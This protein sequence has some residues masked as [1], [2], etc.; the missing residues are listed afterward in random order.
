MTQDSQRPRRRRRETNDTPQIEDTPPP[1]SSLINRFGYLTPLTDEQIE[2]IHEEALV[3]L[4]TAGIRVLSDQARAHLKK[5]G[6]RV[7]NETMMVFADADFITENIAKAPPNFTLTPR[8]PSH[9]ITVGGDIV[10]FGM[11]SGPPNVSDSVRGRRASQFN[12]FK[13][14]IKLGQSFQNIHFFGNQTVAT[15]DLDVHTRHLD[16]ILAT[17][18]LSDKVSACMS[19]G[20]ERVTDAAA[21][22]AIAKGISLDEMAQDPAAITNININS[23]RVLDKEMSDA[24]MAMAEM[25]Q[26][27]IVTPFTLMGAMAPV[28]IPAALTQQN[29]EALFTI[30]LLQSWRAGCKVVYGGFTSNVDMKS[31]A[32]AF[33]TPENALTNM[34]GGQLARRYN[35]PYRS[36]GCNASNTPDAQAVFETQMSLWGA[37][38]GGANLIYHS[39]GWLEGGLVASYE[40]AI[41]DADMLDAFATMMGKISFDDAEFGREAITETPPGGHFFGHGHTLERYKS[42]FFAPMLSDWQNFENWEAAGSL[43]A[44]ERAA[45]A[46]Q[47]RLKTFTPPPI[48]AAVAEALEAYVAR[49]IEEIGDRPL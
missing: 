32:P 25:G 19:V 23:P 3:I 17:L 12:D 24:A 18:T 49:R 30:A 43:T 37:V 2:R 27:V 29:A 31:G 11:V 7:D 33:G 6:C 26:A 9:A 8:N 45:V 22:I 1:F 16:S 46:W 21:M 13:D 41:L 35:L 34:A 4:S 10:N 28:T 44:T 39:A 48:D 36:S 5:E 14:F 20:R 15:N 47:E 38:F 40:K 42:A